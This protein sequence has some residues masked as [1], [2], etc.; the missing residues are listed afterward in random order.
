MI[1]VH[2][3]SESD[4]DS[5][6]AFVASAKKTHFMFNRNFMDYHKDRFTDSSLMIRKGGDL[7]ALLPANISDDV[8]YSHQGLSFGGIICNKQMST[9]LMLEVFES[10]I[11]WS[12]TAGVSK[13]IYKQVPDFYSE[14]PSSEDTYALFRSN[15]N[16]IRID[17]TSL[18]NMRDRI[19]FSS[20]RKR[21]LK[22]AAKH[23]VTVS[24]NSE[25]EGFYK[26]LS[27]VLLAR[28]NAKPVHT[29]EEMK[30]L[31]SRFPENIKLFTAH[32]GAEKE[33]LAGVWVFEGDNW[34]HAQYI[35]SSQKGRDCN[36]LDMI[37]DRLINS[38]YSTKHW[39]DFGISTESQ[40]KVLNYG[41][42]TQKEE[43]GARAAV[44]EFWEILI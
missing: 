38:V 1:Q 28:H 44:H 31:M 24:Q 40:G 30:L 9:P 11:G 19:E 17:V 16:L 15:A 39:F 41:L 10:I 5:W 43:F 27:E 18:I 36:A 21:G 37:F 33:V 22:N 29:L 6:N 2:K 23:E 12:K 13:I 25:I 14:V 7:I 35:V 8:L 34:A 32:I 3:Y 42:V 4:F 26:E 20:R